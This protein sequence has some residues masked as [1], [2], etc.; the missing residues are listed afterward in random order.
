LIVN[1]LLHGTTSGAVALFIS[2]NS[3]A[4]FS[5]LRVSP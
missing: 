3:L 2:S 4:H 1:N 5:N